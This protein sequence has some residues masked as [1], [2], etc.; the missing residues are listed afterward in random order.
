MSSP[1][2]TVP[3]LLQATVTRVG[4]QPALGTIRDGK[5]S[6]RTW[7]EVNADVQRVAGSLRRAGV[8]VDD[9]VV[10]FASNCYGWIL[11]DLAVLWLGAV[12]VPLHRTLST[13]QASELLQRTDAALLVTSDSE[14]ELPQSATPRITHGQLSSGDAESIDT[15][16]QPDDL[17]TILYTSGTTGQPRGVMLSHRNLVANAIATTDAVGTGD[18]ET[19]LCFLPLS[20]VYARTCDLYSW[21]YGGTRLVLAESRETIVRDCQL[22]EPTV[23]NGVP[24][25][26]QKLAQQLHAAGTTGEPGVLRHLLGGK[27][28]HCFCGGAAVAPD[29]ETLFA[30]Q[31]LPLLGGYGLTET[32][33]VVA[34][35]SLENYR[36]GTVGRPLENLQ[37]RLAADGEVLV[38]GPS[39]MRGYWRDEKATAATIVDDWLYT[40]DL[41]EIDAAGNLRIV[42]RKKEMIVLSTGKNVAPAG[43]EQLLAG[44]PLV[45]YACVVGEGQKCLAALII[46]NAD[47][48]RAEIRQ[49]RLWVWSKRRAVTHPTVRALYRAEIDRLLQAQSDHEQVGPFTILP[50]ALSVERGELTPK[51]SLCRGQ[52]RANFA[53]QIDRMYR[54]LATRQ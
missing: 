12:H 48:L 35:S 32:S 23:L 3:E 34:A 11:T 16:V 1:P 53:G 2:S 4:D 21:L 36:P 6:W 44:S 17:A 10:Q 51:L 31:G 29:V 49:R 54:Q 40:G 20:H 22:V 46:P 33:P 8:G 18:H 38:R 47:A 14:A 9:R 15:E 5:L 39:V 28:R 50:R 41:G 42:G 27:L 13:Q 7:A 24:Y 30:E 37:V 19:R 43:V 25:F 52:I 26:Y 45:E